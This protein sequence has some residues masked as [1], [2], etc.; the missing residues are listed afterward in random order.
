MMDYSFF[1]KIF[2]VNHLNSIRITR[3]KSSSEEDTITQLRKITKKYDLKY[4][5]QAELKKLYL[6]GMNKVFSILDT[7]KVSALIISILALTTSLVYFIREKS[8]MLAGLKSIG[9][10]SFQMF[11]LIY[12][13]AL[14]LVSFGILSGILNSI[15]LSPIV[16]FGI[17]RNAFGWVLD[18]QYPLSFVVK[19]PILIPVITFIICLIP[20]YFL[21]QMNISKELKYE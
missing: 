10:S 3:N 7:L 17:N 13:Q 2:K 21:K 9:M 15:V 16:I 11:Q 1:Q 18:F 12:Y 19:L 8:Q 14:F 5:N 6:E 4:I 20:F